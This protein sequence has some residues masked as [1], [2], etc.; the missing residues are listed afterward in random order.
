[1]PPVPATCA[2]PFWTANLITIVRTSTGDLVDCYCAYVNAN[3][4]SECVSAQKGI[5]GFS[6]VDIVDIYFKK[7]HDIPQIILH[8]HGHTQNYYFTVWNKKLGVC[9]VSVQSAFSL[10]NLQY[11]G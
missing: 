5:A 1:M 3:W 7:T 9:W 11:K 2:N 10:E 8:I 6:Y 4:V